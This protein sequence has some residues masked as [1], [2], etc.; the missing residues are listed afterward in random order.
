[1]TD[2]LRAQTSR[3]DLRPAH[4]PEFLQLHAID[5]KG[6]KNIKKK[7]H[8]YGLLTLWVFL[9]CAVIV[10]LYFCISMHKTEAWKDTLV[11]SVNNFFQQA[12]VTTT[13]KFLRQLDQYL[14]KRKGTIDIQYSAD[15][16]AWIILTTFISIAWAL[17][18]TML[19][20]SY[21]N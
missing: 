20:M 2:A 10:G 15:S 16:T 11:Q 19:A 13:T 7:Q 21:R 12:N 18:T 4:N 8:S 1:M 14:Y 3:S 9:T 6:G 17:T 5:Y